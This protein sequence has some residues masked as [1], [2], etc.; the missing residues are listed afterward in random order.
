MIT[1]EQVDRILRL[2]GNGL[3]LVSLYLP[4]EP[5]QPGRRAYRTRLASL[6]ERIGPLAD[7]HSLEHAVRLSLRDDIAKI[8]QRLGEEPQRP[9]TV[10]VFSCSGNGVYEEVWLPRAT[11]E[12]VVVDADPYVRPMLAVLDEYDRTCAVVVDEATAQIWEYHL[13]EVQELEAIRDRTLRGS[14]HV[15]GID[16]DRVRN[17]ADELSKRHY[18]RLI[19]E[20]KRLFKEGGFDLLAVGGHPYQVPAFI[21][22]LPRDLHDR[23]VGR[24]TVDRDTAT[25]A[26]IRDKVRVLVADRAYQEQERL[27]G[28]ILEAVVTKHHATVGLDDT[29]WAGSLAAIRTL[30]VDTE[31]VA[32][33]VVCDRD[34]LL[35][36]T[37]EQCPFCADALREVPDVIEEL[38][39]A[40]IEDGGEVRHIEMETDLRTHLTGALLRFELPPHPIDTE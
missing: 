9:G 20:L 12:R 30:A 17:K 40:V 18:R 22:F 35:A 19:G 24:F 10:V 34:G 25:A 28:E 2:G 14:R 26:D 16:E 39:K 15:A 38:V 33:G 11:H 32:P 31:A 13:D 4:V 7:D 37:G 21:E 36:R 27:A 29:L 1:Q 5:D 8:E 6:L 23:L 3:P